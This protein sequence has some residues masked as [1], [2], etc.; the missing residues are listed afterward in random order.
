MISDELGL[1]T[2]VPVR[3]ETGSCEINA[4]TNRRWYR[5]GILKVEQL[6]FKRYEHEAIFSRGERIQPVYLPG[7]PSRIWHTDGS[8]T[9]TELSSEPETIR[10]PSLEKATDLTESVWP[11]NTLSMLPV[12][13]SHTRTELSDEPETIRV[14][15]LEKATALRAL[16]V[17]NFISSTLPP[18]RALVK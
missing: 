6:R 7:V 17:I 12:D 13:V 9:R 1:V 14:P 16:F 10:V 15:S 8:H 2:L 11:F 4:R 18:L 5:K 3:P